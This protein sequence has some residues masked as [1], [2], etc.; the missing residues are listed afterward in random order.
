[1]SECDDDKVALFASAENN[2]LVW[3]VVL[4]SLNV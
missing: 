3:V 4:S 1:M 2:S